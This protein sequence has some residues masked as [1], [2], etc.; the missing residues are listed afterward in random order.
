VVASMPLFLV[1]KEILEWIRTGQKNIEP[2]MSIERH[3]TAKI[4]HGKN[5]SSIVFKSKV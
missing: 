5:L 3:K 4:P 2:Y 1:K